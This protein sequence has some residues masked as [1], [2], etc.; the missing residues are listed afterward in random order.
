MR[1][2]LLM[3]P[4]AMILLPG[5]DT[6]P[7]GDAAG[8]TSTIDTIGGVERIVNRGRPAAWTLTERLALGSGGGAGE[9]REDE[10]G[11]IGT[12][13][14]TDDGRIFVADLTTTEVRIFGPDGVYRAL[15]GRSGAGPGEF[16]TPA[17]LALLGDTLMVLDPGNGR[18]GL[19]SLDGE[20]LGHL[21][22]MALTGPVARLYPTGRHEVY[23]PTIRVAGGRGDLAFVRQLGSG[24]ADTLAVVRD[25]RAASLSV[26]CRHGPA[27]SFFSSDLSPQSIAAPA[28]GARQAVAWS[29]E[30]RIGFINPAGDTVRTVERDLP[31]RPVTDDEW[32]AEE[33]RFQEFLDGIEDEQCDRRTLPRPDR[34]RLL[35]AL[36]FDDQSRMWIE[37]HAGSGRTFDVYDPDG[38]LIAEAAAPARLERVQPH[39][40]AGRLYLVT[41]DSLEVESVRVYDIVGR[42]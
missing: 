42:G 19:H 18:I 22:Y 15:L 11:R 20:W 35:H 13:I 1:R 38:W 8:V 24:P 40:R 12:V 32:R 23:S 30:Y 29:G 16:R 9:A 34:G 21:P 27:I 33:K 4:A 17:S 7:A 37:R 36:F 2:L 39:V 31:P 3:V 41:A 6:T 26:T 10:F 28:P 14:A 25:S 5:C